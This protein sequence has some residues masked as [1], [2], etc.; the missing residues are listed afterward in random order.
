MLI[1]TNK[2]KMKITAMQAGHG[3]A[4][5]IQQES[6]FTAANRRMDAGK[7]RV[8]FGCRHDVTIVES[9]VRILANQNGYIKHHHT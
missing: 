8:P 5:G 7:E 3:P 2:E 1:A 6:V 9:Y 4:E